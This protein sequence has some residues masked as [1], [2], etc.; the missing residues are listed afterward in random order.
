MQVDNK[1]TKQQLLKNFEHSEF[2]ED[3][4]VDDQ[5]I[6]LG[7]SKVNSLLSSTEETSNIDEK[8]PL[9]LN[10]NMSVSDAI[11]EVSNF[12]GESIPVV[13]DHGILLG[14]LNEAD[15]FLEYLKVQEDISTIEK[16]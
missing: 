13:N 6:L 11:V 3:Y 7:K 9:S 16:D 14:V 8:S 2:T 12:V 10:S 1:V 15:I 5:G 4:F